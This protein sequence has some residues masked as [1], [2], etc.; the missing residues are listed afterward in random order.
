M[1][2]LTVTREKH[3]AGCLGTIKFYIEDANTPDIH[4]DGRPCRLLGKLKNGESASWP[5]DCGALRIFALAD[6][7]SQSY[8]RDQYAIPAGEEDLTLCGRCHFNPANGNAF[9]FAGNTDTIAL[10]Q[11]KRGN[12]RGWIVLL[13][14]ILVGF[15]LGLFVISPLLRGITPDSANPM[16]FSAAGLQ[17]TLT[18]EFAPDHTM[19]GF[20]VCYLSPRVAVF[21]LQEPFSLAEG[22][23][24]LT[25]AE[26]GELV[27][28]ALPHGT[29]TVTTEEDGLL[30]L[31]YEADVEGDRFFY[32]NTLH[33]TG[34]AFWQVCFAMPADLADTQLDTLMTWANSIRF[35]D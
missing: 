24:E 2:T 5:I 3:F 13:A 6:R 8:C 4:I 14:A 15:L 9:R 19:E 30:Y 32:F 20:T 28:E 18:E 11:R 22:F 31:T 26:Y 17:I 35:T 23:G 16:T 27:L 12:R 29:E 33:K 34:D 10:E 21:A 25:A 7:A 1:R